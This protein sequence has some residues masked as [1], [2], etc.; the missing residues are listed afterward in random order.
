MANARAR[1]RI[2]ARIQERVAYC[3]EFELADPRSAFI[4]ITRVEVSQDLSSAKIFY[5]VLGT[6]GERSRVAHMLESASGFVRQKLGRVLETRRTPRLVWIFDDSIERLAEMD[7]KIAAALRHDREIN[8]KAHSG[9]EL[10][11]PAEDEG[12]ELAG[13]YEDFLDAQEEEER[14]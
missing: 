2:E 9:A 8:P 10:A 13:E 4:T 12:T 11:P 1:A 6:E 7:A 3:V 14:S 5:S